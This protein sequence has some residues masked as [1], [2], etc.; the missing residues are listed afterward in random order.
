MLGE[1]GIGK[2]AL[3]DHAA[4]SGSG[5]R[6]LRARGFESEGEL[7]F[8]ALGDV[9][10]PL[11]GHLASL[12]DAQRSALE[13]ALAIGPPVGGDPLTVCVA[14]LNLLAAAADERPILAIVDDAQWLDRASAS[15]L[16][17]LGHHLHSEGVALLIGVREGAGAFDCRGL[18]VL[19]LDGLTVKDGAELAKRSGATVDAVADRLAELTGGNP[20]ALLE[21]SGASSRFRDAPP[22]G[23]L[24][25]ATSVARVY[26]E[27]FRSLPDA[28]RDLLVLAA[29]SDSG[30]LSVLARCAPGLGLSLEDLVPAEAVLLVAVREGRVEFRHPLARSAVYA[31]ALP[32]RRRY[33]YNLALSTRCPSRGSDG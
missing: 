25:V 2:S 8:G 16:A 31:E 30:D 4:E 6:L 9:L 3:L 26:V 21:L 23:P 19:R 7:A 27:R 33:R 15:V 20:L 22:G 13:S 18:D 28:T 12:H 32:S 5:M 17:F 24:P 1:P 29:A 11:A 14:A 10:R